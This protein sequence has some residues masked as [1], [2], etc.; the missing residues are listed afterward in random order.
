VTADNNLTF[1]YKFALKDGSV[2][3]FDVLLDAETLSL[4]SPENKHYPDWTRLSYNQC[5]NCPL[6]ESKHPLCP[7]AANMV[8]VVE[9]F[10]ES[11]SFDEA[12]IEITTE[13]RSYSKHTSLQ[14]GISSLIGLVMATSNCPILDKL[15]P[16]AGTHLPFSTPQET[17]YRALSMYL[18]AQHFVAK[19]GKKP[20]WEF[21]ELAKA[22]E[23]I[24]LVN[25]TFCKRIS[26]SQVQDAILNAVVRLNSFA[27]FATLT[28]EGHGVTNLEKVFHAY[29]EEPATD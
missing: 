19:K 1:H 7:V 16:M 24:T 11:I 26:H 6:K 23:D 12:D 29:L 10:K 8:G 14:Q 17:V 2:K 13:A 15:K 18:L 5:P 9:F 27:D 3:E 25:M 21:K 20:D 28:L 22:Y 4:I